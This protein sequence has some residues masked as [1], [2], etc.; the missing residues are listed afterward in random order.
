VAAGL[1]LCFISSTAKTTSLSVSHSDTAP[2]VLLELFFCFVLI[3][4][5]VRTHHGM[6]NFSSNKYKMWQNYKLMGTG[7]ELGGAGEV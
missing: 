7:S 1:W 6:E 4:P 5:E 3:H 2:Q